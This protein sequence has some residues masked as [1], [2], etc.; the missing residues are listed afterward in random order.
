MPVSHC[1]LY[2]PAQFLLLIAATGR[3]AL[4]NTVCHRTCLDA[5]SSHGR[6]PALQALLLGQQLRAPYW[7]SRKHCSTCLSISHL[8]TP[9]NWNHSKPHCLYLP[10]CHM[11]PVSPAHTASNAAAEVAITSQLILR[12]P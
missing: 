1:I 2:M 12:V 4:P 10:G 9:S 11:Q 7:H 3:R 5:C 6:W 8:R